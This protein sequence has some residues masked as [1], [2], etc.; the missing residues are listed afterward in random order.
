MTIRVML[1]DDHPI[2]RTGIA[3]MLANTGGIEVVG[4]AANG[5]EALEVMP[6]AQ[7]DVLLLDLRMPVMDGPTLIEHLRSSGNDIGILVLTTYDTDADI[8]RA[9]EAGANGYLLKDTS[10]SELIQAIQSTHAGDG[11][12]APSITAKLM[13]SMRSGEKTKLSTRELDVLKLVATGNSNKEIASALHVSQATV[14]THL[15]HIFRKLDVSDRT[16]AVTVSMDRG[17]L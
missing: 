9:T 11:W 1:I 4:E 14:K 5:K 15:I 13:R 7:P 3:G 2:V 8:L 6:T 16:A 17:I 10:Q 12:L